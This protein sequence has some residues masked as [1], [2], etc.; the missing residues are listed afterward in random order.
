[1]KNLLVDN[2]QFDA[3]FQ[4]SLTESSARLGQTRVNM[5]IK[6]AGK[7]LNIEAQMLRNEA[8][9][10]SFERD[11]YPV[12]VLNEYDAYSAVNKAYWEENYGQEITEII[13]KGR[14]KFC[15]FVN[16]VCL[17]ESSSDDWK[18]IIDD[19][20]K[21]GGKTEA[22]AY[23]NVGV[24]ISKVFF[25]ADEKYALPS[26]KFALVVEKLRLNDEA[27]IYLEE[28]RELRNFLMREC[29]DGQSKERL[30]KAVDK[31]LS[32]DPMNGIM[33]RTSGMEIQKLGLLSGLGLSPK[34]INAQMH[35]SVMEA[36]GISLAD[37]QKP[38]L[39]P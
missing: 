4:T 22:Y 15:I 1:M 6:P 14:I 24:G 36:L 31:R 34:A 35:K 25:H 29:V 12:R 38:T 23:E 10:N 39:L 37:K 20:R 21:R 5:F 28:I 8:R 3:V 18:L 7:I 27:E 26:T 13:M 30:M 17:D 9:K 11:D 2:P 16:S 33:I 19:I 32:D